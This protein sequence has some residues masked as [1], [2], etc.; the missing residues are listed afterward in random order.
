MIILIASSFIRTSNQRDWSSLGL[1]EWQSGW[2]RQSPAPP[3]SS[4]APGILQDGGWWPGGRRWDG[5][6]AP[7]PTTPSR[8]TSDRRPRRDMGSRVRRLRGGW[9]GASRST[10]GWRQ[11]Q[12]WIEERVH[13]EGKQ[14]HTDTRKEMR[15][16]RNVLRVPRQTVKRPKRKWNPVIYPSDE[17]ILKSPK[18]CDFVK[19]CIVSVFLFSLG[20]HV[21]VFM[22]VWFICTWGW[23]HR[24]RYRN[25]YI[26]MIKGGTH[27]IKKM[28]VS[29]RFEL[30][31]RS[32]SGI[33]SSDEENDVFETL[34]SG[35]IFFYWL[36]PFS[37][38]IYI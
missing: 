23:R 16:N 1:Q 33:C 17:V 3:S 6:G 10:G 34:R 22:F 9:A 11:T 2:R 7:W 28:T 35:F 21:T 13:R 26:E 18:R 29:Y 5:S 12:K 31:K 27:T 20:V 25:A 8:M 36:F 19:F 38:L 24:H 14:G 32:S 4:S 37:I 30:V 15:Q